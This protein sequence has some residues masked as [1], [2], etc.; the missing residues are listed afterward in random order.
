[1]DIQED[2]KANTV[3]ATFELPG[4]KKEDVNIDVHHN[5]LS[6]SGEVKTSTERNENGYAIRER[7][8]GGFS[9]TLQLPV[10][11]KVCVPFSSSTTGRSILL[12]KIA[13]RNQGLHGGWSA[14]NYFPEGNSR[15]SSEEDYHQLSPVLV[16]QFYICTLLALPPDVTSAVVVFPNDMH[17]TFFL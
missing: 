1:M 17:A 11:I 2:E 13:G 7:S 14:Q 5:R 4:L 9:R 10:G 15:A 8:Y 12:F 3:I 16:Y 6:I